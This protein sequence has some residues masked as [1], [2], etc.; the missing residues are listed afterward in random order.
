MNQ[1]PPRQNCPEAAHDRAVQ[2]V[3]KKDSASQLDEQRLDE[4]SCGSVRKREI[5]I[6][7][8]AE[9]NP[10]RVFQDIAEVPENREPGILPHDDGG[11]A[12]EKKWSR[13][14]VQRVPARSAFRFQT[15]L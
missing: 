14:P 11:R 13:S 7:E 9:G 10:V 3:V 2:H 1:N 8:I 5:A 12:Q 4:K 6:G 15:I